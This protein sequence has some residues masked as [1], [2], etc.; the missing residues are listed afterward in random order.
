GRDTV[1]LR[2]LLVSGEVGLC[3]LS[4]LVG[5][6]LLQSFSRVLNVQRGFDVADIQTVSIGLPST[7]YPVP[8]R[9]QF[10]RSALERIHSIRGV[11][12]AGVSTILPLASGTGPGLSITIPGWSGEKP[13]LY[14]RA[15]DADYFRT[16]GISQQA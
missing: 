14:L 13:T 9:V 7:R 11:Q 12:S 8:K 5:A 15:V 10:L 4:L 1:R 3:V 16:M 6:L 2:A